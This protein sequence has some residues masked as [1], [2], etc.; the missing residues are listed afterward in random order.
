[1]RRLL[2]DISLEELQYMRN[3]EG[4]SNFEIA[5][6][7]GCSSNTIFRILGPQ[8]KH[9][10][11]PQGLAGAARARVKADK[12]C[13][14]SVAR[15]AQ[16]EPEE[17]CLMVASRT[18]RLTGLVSTYEVNENAGTVTIIRPDGN[19]FD[20]KLDELDD[21]IKELSAIRRHTK[22]TTPMEAW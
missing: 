17:A 15:K 13:T 12:D 10:R 14:A 20:L 8:P 1:M 2:D 7:V 21:M 18:I 4:L 11:T 16:E 3:E 5:E 22:T 9:I 6:K 19:G